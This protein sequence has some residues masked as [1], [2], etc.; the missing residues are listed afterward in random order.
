MG[1]AGRLPED[2]TPPSYQGETTVGVCPEC[3]RVAHIPADR[4]LFGP[5]G[6]CTNCEQQVR[7]RV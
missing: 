7:W 4:D 5:K 2:D 3:G 1:R 6:A